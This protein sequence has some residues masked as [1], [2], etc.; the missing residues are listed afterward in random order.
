MILA[1]TGVSGNLGGK[2]AAA[3]RPE[4]TLRCLDM[5]GGGAD[6]LTADLARYHDSWA[7]HFEGV[8]TVLHFAAESQ[9]TASWAEVQRGNVL[10]TANVLRAARRSQLRRI[11][12]ASSNQV[13]GGYRFS[14]Q[15][16]TTA[17]APAPLNPYAISKLF[18]EELGRSFAEETGISFIALRIGNIQPGENLPHPG[19]GLG[20][21]GQQM[22]LSNRDFIAGVRAAISV[23]GVPFAVVNL[24]SNNPGMPWDMSETRR[25]LGFVPQDGFT[26]DLSPEDRAEEDLARQARLVP[27]QWLDQRFQPLKG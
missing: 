22:W 15:L 12:F 7:R 5:R 14:G 2:L 6:C 3:L 4:H 20:L 8:D 27:G 21:W 16:I 17:M 9:P 23:A 13:M 25:V 10:A 18:G 24:V 19:M 11:V 26:P 1:I